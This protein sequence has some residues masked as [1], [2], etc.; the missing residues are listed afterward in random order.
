MRWSRVMHPQ[1]LALGLQAKTS[2]PDANKATGRL[3]A[4]SVWPDRDTKVYKQRP[5][6]SII[7]DTSLLSFTNNDQVSG[8]RTGRVGHEN[9]LLPVRVASSS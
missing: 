5:K 6:R 1:L 3:F 8:Q 4:S 2:S 7:E 9:T